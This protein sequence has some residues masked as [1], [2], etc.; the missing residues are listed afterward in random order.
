MNDFEQKIIEAGKSVSMTD[1]ERASI[2]ARLISHT[3]SAKSRGA[4]SPY[5]NFFSSALYRHTMSLAFVAVL[6]FTGGL[7]AIADKALPGALL[8][9]FKTGINEKVLSL[10]AVSPNSKKQLQITLAERR[11]MEAEIISADPTIP[12]E[13]KTEHAKV[14]DTQITEALLGEGEDAA[15]EEFAVPASTQ[16]SPEDAP[17]VS[18][19]SV[20]TVMMMSAT[21]APEPETKVI[22]PVMRKK[23]E[24][25]VSPAEIKELRQNIDTVRSSL[26]E[27][28]KVGEFETESLSYE[29][30]LLRAQKALFDAGNASSTPDQKAQRVKE[31][32]ATLSSIQ[33]FL[34]KELKTE[35][36][37]V[38]P[39]VQDLKTETKT[40]ENEVDAKVDIQI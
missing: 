38:T 40:E 39:P 1:T 26:V 37:N 29:A 21:I 19:K 17:S 8:Y 16:M 23:V 35:I 6:F 13:V 22:E 9:P 31:A 10:F 34:K 11:L 3:Q 20:P 4:A 36:K 27:K 7:S 25:Q 28:R 12:Q 14:L 33:E 2:R 24:E 15:T 18:Q 30:K 5:I 32:R